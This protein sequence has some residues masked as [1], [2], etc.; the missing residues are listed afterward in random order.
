MPSI[1]EYRGDD[2]IVRVRPAFREAL[3]IEYIR[4]GSQLILDGERIGNNWEGIKAVIPR[5][6]EDEKIAPVVTHLEAAFRGLGIEYLI[7]RL[8]DAEPVNEIDRQAAI[9]E[10]RDMGLG[11]EASSDKKQVKLEKIAGA[12]RRDAETSR[13]QALRLMSLIH[14]VSGTRQHFEILAKSK[15]F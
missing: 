11:V 10:L 12:L 4:D 8:V 15:E 7:I 9:T 1:S 5:D 3:S 14:D 6:I 2:F 13:K